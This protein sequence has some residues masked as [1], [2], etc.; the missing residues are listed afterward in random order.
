MAKPSKIKVKTYLPT[1]PFPP[2]AE[3]KPIRTERLIIRPYTEE[4]LD[5]IYAIRTQPEVMHFS[6]VGQ[7]DASKDETRTSYLARYLPPNDIRTYNNILCLASTGEIIGMGGMP[8]T[9]LFFG[10]PE[11]G[12]MLKKEYWGQGYATE[13]VR[14]FIDHWWTLPR[15]EAEIEVVEGSVDRSGE[16]PE[17]LSAIAD[18]NNPRSKHVLEKAGFRQFIRWTEPDTRVGITDDITLV[19]FVLESPVQGAKVLS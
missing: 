12:Y 18:D 11:V 10:W 16:V 19:G 7:I 4:D 6:A 13:F 5:G 15:S 1:Q 2:N 3:R 14:A 9:D 17:M 8:K